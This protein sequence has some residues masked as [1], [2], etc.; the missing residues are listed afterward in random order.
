MTDSQIPPDLENQLAGPGGQFPGTAETLATPVGSDQPI[1]VKI[2][3][4]TNKHL[5]LSKEEFQARSAR[6]REIDAQADAST[7]Q[8]QEP[9]KRSVSRPDQ[10]SVAPTPKPPRKNKPYRP[11]GTKSQPNPVGTQPEKLIGQPCPVPST[12]A[13][14]TPPIPIST[15]AMLEQ[16]MSRLE[17]GVDMI[18]RALAERDE[19]HEQP[20]SPMSDPGDYQAVAQRLDEELQD[21]LDELDVEPEPRESFDEPPPHVTTQVEDN[22]KLDKGLQELQQMILKRTPQK[23]FRQYWAQ[24]S[25]TAQ[26][27]EWPLERREAFD[28]VFNSMVAHPKFVYQMSKFLRGSRSGNCIGNEQIARVCGMVAGFLTVYQLAAAGR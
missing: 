12:T 16:R 22:P 19:R 17:R 4:Q 25:R 9:P 23:L 15:D 6:Q 7:D 26:Y 2:G 24:L 1:Q 14:P 28:E 18:V 10:A 27:N 21:D 5:Q 8:N 11:R 13:A 20:H 3:Q